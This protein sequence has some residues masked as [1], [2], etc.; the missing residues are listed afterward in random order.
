MSDT[1]GAFSLKFWYDGKKNIYIMAKWNF[2]RKIVIIFKSN[3]FTLIYWYS[4]YKV[5]YIVRYDKKYMY[6]LL[7]E[8]H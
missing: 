6:N 3:S 4:L 8:F 5:V 7:N 1:T 2:L